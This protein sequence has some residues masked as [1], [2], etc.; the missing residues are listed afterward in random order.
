MEPAL[1]EQPPIRAVGYKRAIRG[2]AAQRQA[3]AAAFWGELRENGRLDRLFALGGGAPLLGVSMGF[4][5]NGYDLYACVETAA[6]PPEGMETV[7]VEGG[8]YAAFPC[9]GASPEAVSARWQELYQ[10]WFFVSGYGHCG[11]AE[12]EVYPS[13]DASSCELRAPVKKLEAQAKIRPPTHARSLFIMVLCA[14]V[15]LLV[16]SAFTDAGSVPLL[17]AAAGL[18]VGVAINYLLKKREEKKD[19]EKDEDGQ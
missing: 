13:P 6:E 11:A 10:R 3:L 15:F 2:E 7:V 12:I 8:L 19:C 1:L 14:L 18:A 17:F 5:K 4:A 9:E 16:G